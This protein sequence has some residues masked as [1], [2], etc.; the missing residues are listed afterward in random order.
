MSRP[1]KLSVGDD[2]ARTRASVFFRLLLALPH[3]VWLAIWGIA[4][5]LATIANWVVTLASGRPWGAAH[6][7]L[8]RY[9]RYAVHV[10]AYAGLLAQ[11]YPGFTGGGDYPIDVE[12]PPPAPQR[13]WTVLLR[14]PLAIPALLL[15]AMLTTGAY[16]GAYDGATNSIGGVMAAAAFLGW[17]ATLALGRMPRGLRDAGAYGLVYGAQLSA[18]LYLLT[19][20]YP[21]SDPL[22][23]LDDLPARSDPIELTVED[24]LRRSRVTVCFRLLLAIPHLVWLVLWGIAAAIVVLVNWFATL[25]NGRSPAVLHDF[26][27]PY[28]RYATHV[29]AYVS[30]AANPYPGFEGEPGGY[31]VD[32]RVTEPAPQNRWTVAFRLILMLPAALLANAYGAVVLVAAVLG[33]FAALVRG[34]LPRGLRNAI[35]LGLR[36][37]A[38]LLGYQMLLTDRYPY[39]GPTA[40][41]APAE[42]A[43]PRFLPPDASA[44]P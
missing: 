43:A 18:Y 35:A 36:Y 34:E 23:A 1:V 7:F 8:A 38:Q 33:W 19:D 37:N 24:D 41:A 15:G 9:L 6:A 25:V 14:I 16:D 21:D 10:Y 12:V 3:L 28:L 30:L 32:L 17:F 4:A 40:A 22:A 26:L 27:A 31:P 20:R 5:L 29:T 42:G 39:S 11:P 13:R 44:S 2:L